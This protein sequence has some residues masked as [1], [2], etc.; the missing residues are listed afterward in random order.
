MPDGFDD[1]FK[2]LLPGLIGGGMMKGLDLDDPKRV[3]KIIDRVLDGLFRLVSEAAAN[4]LEATLGVL[5]SDD[6][7]LEKVVQ[8]TRIASNPSTKPPADPPSRETNIDI[9]DGD[10]GDG[11][12]D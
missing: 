10:D 5:A 8:L 1:L 4:D 11:G 12:D 6:H 2:E 7:S 3:V 9:E